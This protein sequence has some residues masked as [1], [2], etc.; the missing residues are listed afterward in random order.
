[1][2]N[3]REAE[4]ERQRRK[5]KGTGKGKGKRKR[6]RTRKRE[7]VL[8]QEGVRF[9]EGLSCSPFR[10]VGRTMRFLAP[11]SVRFLCFLHVAT[12][13]GTDGLVDISV[14]AKKH[15][16]LQTAIFN[17]RSE[18]VEVARHRSGT[19]V[20]LFPDFCLLLLPAPS[21][22]RWRIDT[23]RLISTYRLP[24]QRPGQGG[25][26]ARVPSVAKEVIQSWRRASNG[27]QHRARDAWGVQGKVAASAPCAASQRPQPPAR[28]LRATSSTVFISIGL[29]PLVPRSVAAG[30]TV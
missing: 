15:L 16:A 1:M 13:P 12:T 17:T 26:L 7:R 22:D 24:L 25:G 27:Q 14:G 30:P 5:G 28:K 6:Q 2:E 3:E 4:R 10:V 29:P 8:A 20:N 19:N 21:C 23:D 9:C 11:L 18:Y